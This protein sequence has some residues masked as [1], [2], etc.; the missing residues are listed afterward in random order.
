MF[1]FILFDLDGT[2]TDP[3]EGI[4]KC[5]QYALLK[6]NVANP[7]PDTLTPFIGPPLNES[8]MKFYNMTAQEA[9]EAIAVYR[10]RF[11]TIGKYE[12]VVYDGIPAMLR[13]LKQ[14]GIR[15]AVASS[16]PTVFVEDIL[17]H[18]KL[19]KYFDVVVGSELDGR[20]VQ[21]E[22]VVAEA[23]K[24][25]HGGTELTEENRKLTAMVGDRKF[26]IQGAH[27]FGL[28]G[29]L[30]TYGYLSPGELEEAHP[31]ITA[32]TVS[33]LEKALLCEEEPVAG[34]EK[35]FAQFRND[36]RLHLF[37][38]AFVPL[39]LYLL[40][41]SM[42]VFIATAIVN[43]I[44]V[45]D[46]L[47]M[48][49]LYMVAHPADIDAWAQALGY[50]AAILAI[51]RYYK[52]TRDM[53]PSGMNEAPGVLNFFRCLLP[54]IS[55]SL[56]LNVLMRQF[57]LPAFFPQYLEALKQQE[58]ITFETGLVL[59]C[60]AAP[61]CEEMMFRGILQNRLSM[62]FSERVGILVS[63]IIFGVLHIYPLEV[64]YAFVLGLMISGCY[65]RYHKLWVP[66]L[67]HAV[68]N[69]IVWTLLRVL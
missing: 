6:L 63:A 43:A 18:F 25:L 21:K 5:V 11:S 45:T 10:E 23:L 59:F 54:V 67:I 66:I 12:N 22:E 13:R 42:V 49:S 3:K 20:R 15:L 36:Q 53:Y 1:K 51:L 24:Q 4:T 31:D 64:I 62:A 50:L 52:I 30:V 69:F 16:K 46:P 2:L 34:T 32:D 68:T 27:A 44:Y 40:I 19:R 28:T 33:E 37:S 47:S 35:R 14:K 9:E 8:F 39:I 26:D 7:D 38:S 58:Q 60:I 57:N 17:K 56:L 65:K 29:V 55:V 41:S 61:V 48:V